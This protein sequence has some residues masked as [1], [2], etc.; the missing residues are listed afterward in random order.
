MTLQRRNFDFATQCRLAET[1]RHFAVQIVFFACKN[2]VRAYV[3]HDIKIARWTAVDPR[4]PFS[5][6][7]DAIAFIYAR[8]NFDGKYFLLF[9]ASCTAA[10][11]TRALHDFATALAF[12]TG[13]LDGKEPLRHAHLALT[14]PR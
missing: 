12:G 6:Q 9:Q 14:V 11:C 8:W 4:L 3:H 2:L 5:G 1:H 13:L 7:T 10:G